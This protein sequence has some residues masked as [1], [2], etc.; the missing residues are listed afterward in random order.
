MT[1]LRTT[2]LVALG[3]NL[4]SQAGNPAETLA[5]ALQSLAGEGLELA[6]LSR[7]YRTPCFPKGEGPDYVNAAAAYRSAWPPEKVL[8]ALHRVE[9]DFGRERKKRWA[10]RN[11]DLDLIAAGN[12][13][14][15][16]RDVLDRWMGLTLDLQKVKMP[17]QLILPHPRIQERAF[18]LVPLADI[19][20]DWVHPVLDL[21][22]REMLDALPEADRAEVEAL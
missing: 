22:V 18:V 10:A 4:K 7:F 17:D 14:V 12:R 21:S 6:A 8:A 9:A 11:L 15:P 20:R 2:Y 16:N 5:A 1:G 3:A 13:I 19:A